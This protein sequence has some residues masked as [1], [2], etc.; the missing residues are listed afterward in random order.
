MHL[1]RRLPPS[2]QEVVESALA[3]TEEVACVPVGGSERHRLPRRLD[4]L[5][6][7]PLDCG[8]IRLLPG[9]LAPIHVAAA[10]DQERLSLIGIP[11]NKGPSQLETVGIPAPGK[12][13]I[14]DC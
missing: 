8:V 2:L 3:G 13:V 5:R 14:T 9:D 11:G 1:G 4:R 12:K 6:Q 10:Q 7:V